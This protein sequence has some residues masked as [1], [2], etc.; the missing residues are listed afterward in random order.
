MVPLALNHDKEQQTLNQSHFS[1]SITYHR[2][3]VTIKLGGGRGERDHMCCGELLEEKQ[4][5]K[6]NKY[7]QLHLKEFMGICRL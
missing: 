3:V 2:I 7:I 4:N 1:Q 6:C 5:K